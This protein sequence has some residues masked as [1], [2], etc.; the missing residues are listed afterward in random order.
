MID[1]HFRA[2]LAV[3]S[4]T[5]TF[6]ELRDFLGCEDAVGYERGSVAR[7]SRR[8]R[9][10]SSWT[11]DLVTEAGVHAG[12]E[13]LSAA[14]DDLGDEL[15]QRLRS[16]RSQGCSVLMVAVQELSQDARSRGLELSLSALTWLASAGARLI[17]DQ[18]VIC[19]DLPDV[20]C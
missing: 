2:Y 11:I 15:A 13:G 4:E 12:T 10:E 18:Y 9:P 1:A 8:V 5:H 20:P 17:V 3:Q 6:V 7:F 19:D 16:L 14:I